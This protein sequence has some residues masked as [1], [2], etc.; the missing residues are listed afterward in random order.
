MPGKSNIPRQR[1]CICQLPKVRT[2]YIAFEQGGRSIKIAASA[3]RACEFELN[4]GKKISFSIRRGRAG[5]DEAVD[6][7]EVHD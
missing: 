6:L 1:G 3:L 2:K 5:A 4:E 7:R